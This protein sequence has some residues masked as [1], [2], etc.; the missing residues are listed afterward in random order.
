VRTPVKC[1][2][3]RGLS[4]RDQRANREHA[5]VR[6]QGE[7]GFAQLKAFK[8]LRRVRISPSRITTLT[9]SIHTVIRLRRSFPYW[10]NVFIHSLCHIYSGIG[11]PIH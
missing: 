7:R 3:G 1:K 11:K 5:R 2:P 9:R 8:A 4:L 6:C 10:V